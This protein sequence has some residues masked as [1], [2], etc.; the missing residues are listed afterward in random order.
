VTSFDPRVHAFRPDLADLRLVGE[1]EAARF[2]AGV[3]RRVVASV[4]PVRHEPRA[5]AAIDSEALRGETVRVF[6]ATPEGW[7]WVQLEADGYVGYVA[8]NALGPIDPKPTH[9]VTALRTFVYPG[10]DMKLP[11]VAVLSIGTRL[12]LGEAVET[13]KT[14][15][16][17]LADGSGAVVARHVA[18]MDAP[19]QPDFVAV[20]MRFLETPYLWGGRSAF[21]IDCSGLVQTALALSGIAVPRD[22]DQQAAALG[23]PVEGGVEADL[24]RG[25]LV[26]WK[27][28]V[29]I[30]SDP[31]TLLH[32]SGYHMAVVMEPLTETVARYAGAGVSPAMV[33]RIG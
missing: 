23:E 26:F 33:R 9:R 18:P 14:P 11:P 24:A 6:E 25:D 2:V 28:H 17:R 32:A 8:S 27:G 15:Y 20:A 19:P 4:T 21:G 31:V 10:A 12:A 3:Q 13:R 1:V 29:G 5:G 30:M 7:S 16:F 22:S